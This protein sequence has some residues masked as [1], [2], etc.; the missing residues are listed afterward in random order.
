MHS[1]HVFMLLHILYNCCVP[2]F[3]CVVDAMIYVWVVTFGKDRGGKTSHS[4]SARWLSTLYAFI[5]RFHVNA[6]SV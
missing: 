4:L 1:Q 5:K 6:Y 2:C 3:P